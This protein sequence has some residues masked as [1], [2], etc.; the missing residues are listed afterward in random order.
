MCVCKLSSKPINLHFFNAHNE[1]LLHKVF[2]ISRLMKV[3]VGV[4]GQRLAESLIILDIT[5]PN[6]KLVFF[7]IH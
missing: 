7:I 1:R 2:V 5:E 6:L 4:I 3:E